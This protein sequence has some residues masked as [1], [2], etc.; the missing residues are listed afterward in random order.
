MD[1]SNKKRNTEFCTCSYP[2]CTRKGLCCECVQYHLSI[3]EIPGCFFPPKAEATYDRSKK[4]FLSIH[5]D[6]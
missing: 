1:C 3:N 2:G 6:Q 5:K 4:Y